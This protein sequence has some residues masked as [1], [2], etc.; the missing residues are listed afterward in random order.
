MDKHL[1]TL[2]RGELERER[3]RLNE[4][5]ATITLELSDLDV[6]ERVFDRLTGAKRGTV[7]NGDEPTPQGVAKAAGHEGMTVREM[8][9]A[10]L[11]DARQRGLPGIAPKEARAYMV[12]VY[13]RDVGQQVNTTLHRMLTV[14][15][16]VNKDEATG[17]YSLPL[18]EKPVDDTTVESPSTGLFDNPEAKGREAGPGGGA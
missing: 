7:S 3:D 10:A 16:E 14:L 9:K 13:G 1:I 8:I 2:R 11:M 4:R 6:A 18:K 5:L 12:S 15:K 17:L